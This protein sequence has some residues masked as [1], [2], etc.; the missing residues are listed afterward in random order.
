MIRNDLKQTILRAINLDEWDL[1]DETLASEVPG[2]DSLSHVNVILAVE[3]TFGVKFKNVEVLKLK[4]VGD[5]QR[6]LETKL[7][8]TTN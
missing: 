8:G 5:L 2:W 6:L 3:K 1:L 7:G 4:N